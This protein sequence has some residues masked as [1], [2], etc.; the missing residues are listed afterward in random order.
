VLRPTRG[1]LHATAGAALPPE[2]FVE[3][4]RLIA[5]ASRIAPKHPGEE[6]S[7]VAVAWSVEQSLDVRNLVSGKSFKRFVE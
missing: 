4:D 7:R 6:F 3:R 2:Q 5:V 1:S